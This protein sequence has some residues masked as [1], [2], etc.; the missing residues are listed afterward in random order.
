MGRFDATSDPARPGPNGSR[1]LALP[2]LTRRSRVTNGKRMFVELQDTNSAWARRLRDLNALLISDLGG[3]DACSEA[4][5]ALVRRAAMLTLQCELLEQRW[6]ERIN[7]AASDKSLLIYQRTSS[8]LRRILESLGLQRRPR[9]VT[10]PRLDQY[11][12]LK[13][14]AQQE[15]A[16][17]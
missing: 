9:D 7:G 14:R 1:S 2:P 5:K 8:A 12:E 13:G 11:L 3:N 15:E 17:A 10:P 4:E 16:D 6:A